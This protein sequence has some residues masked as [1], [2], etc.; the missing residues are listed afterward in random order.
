MFTHIPRPWGLL[1][2]SESFSFPSGHATL[3]VIFYLGIVFLLIKSFHIKYRR[4]IYYPAGFIILAVSLSRLYLG[5]HWFTDIIGGW[6]LGASLF[7]LIAL[8]YNR[9][10]EKIFKPMG[11]FLT[12]ILTFMASYSLVTLHEFSRLKQNYTALDWPTHTLTVK[13]WWEQKGRHLPLYRINRFGIATQILNL[14]WMDDLSV[15]QKKLMQN[16]WEIPPEKDWISV[17]HRVSDVESAAHLPVVAPLYLDKDPV[18]VLIKH[19]N[20][21]KKLIVLRL[22]NSYILIK[23]IQKPLWVGSVE[24]VPRTYSFIFKHRHTQII[25]SPQL[26]FRSVPAEYDIKQLTVTLHPSFRP[27]VQPLILIKPK[28]I[29]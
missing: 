25:L 13:A 4:F 28:N 10:A 24:M 15:I 17:L 6:L 18:L 21:N 16:G 26:L 7:M 22:W 14:Q 8:S 2:S 5:V 23:D 9:Q 12:I 11:I 3:T 27:R 19:V 1:Q 20:G 29:K